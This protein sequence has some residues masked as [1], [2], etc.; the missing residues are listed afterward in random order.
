MRAFV[1]VQ[2]PGGA[3]HT[4]FHGDFIGRLWTASLLL[5]DPGVSEAHALVSLRGRELKLLGLR[6]ALMVD[7]RLVQETTLSPGMRIGLTRTLSLVVT[8][9]EL[10]DSVLAIEGDDLPRHV[11]AG[12]CSLRL[13]PRPQLLPGHQ[14]PADA[15]FWS[16]DEDWSVRLDGVT[17]PLRAG[18]AWTLEGRTF[19]AVDVPLDS[20]SGRQTV[21]EGGVMTPLSLVLRYESAHIRREGAPI[22]ALGG[23]LA[24][25]LTELALFGGPVAWEVLAAEVWSDHADRHLLRKRLDVTL[26]K[27]RARLRD[28]RIRTDLV[29]AD[30]SGRFEL[31]LYAEDKL[32]VDA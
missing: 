8:D 11:L 7:G 32:D 20:A 2:D 21:H 12:V 22:V 31:L 4:L 17:R 30:G 13:S 29:R 9:V 10:P 16:V 15:L 28:E 14:D 26:A 6:G 5:D 19:R 27:L 3:E 24:R 1:R 25:L 23:V 18:D